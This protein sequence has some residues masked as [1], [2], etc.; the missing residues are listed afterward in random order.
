M[1]KIFALSLLILL[2]LSGISSAE[3]L[4]GPGIAVANTK[5][6]KIQGYIRNGIFT[7]H[8]VPY[9]DAEIFMPPAKLSSWDGVRMAVTYGAQSPQGHITRR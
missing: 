3:I 7:Y 1:R 8:G 4:A 6:G 2:A 5:D 9:A